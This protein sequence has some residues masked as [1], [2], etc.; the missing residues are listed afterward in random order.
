MRE[1]AFEHTEE[2]KREPEAL[3]PTFAYDG[4]DIAWILSNLAAT[5][6]SS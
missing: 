5:R 3:N 6:D 1:I 2:S 4:H